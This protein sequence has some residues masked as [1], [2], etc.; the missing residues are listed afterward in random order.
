[1]IDESRVSWVPAPCFRRDMLR[2]NDTMWEPSFRG[3]GGVCDPW[4]MVLYRSAQTQHSITSRV[5][6]ISHQSY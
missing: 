1:M 4:I 2:R 5:R 3:Y 6:E